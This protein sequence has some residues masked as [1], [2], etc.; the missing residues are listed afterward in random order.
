MKLPSGVR[1]RPLWRYS[2][3]ALAGALGTALVA[4]C[5]VEPPA[6]PS[7]NFVISIPV[8]NDSTR[9]SELVGDRDD[10]LEIDDVTGGMKLKVTMPLPGSSGAEPEILGTA[11]V[12]Q[13]LK[14]TPQA[15]SFSTAIGDLSIPGQTI[16]EVEV[17]MSTLLGRDIPTGTTIPSLPGSTFDIE[18]PMPLAGVT[19]LEIA[20]GGLSVAVDNGFPVDLVNL[21]LILRDN[22]AG[23]AI[24]DQIDLGTVAANGGSAA[25][26]FSLEGRTISGN[27]A[28]AVAGGTADGTDLTVDEDPSL[29]INSELETLLVTRATALIPQQEFE[30]S[31]TLDF[32]DDRIQVTEAV[33]SEGDI[34]LVVTNNIPI[35]MEVELSLPD[36]QDANGNAQVLLLDSLVAG[37]PREITFDLTN[38]TF[39][40]DHPLQMRLAYR[41]RT[42]ASD[43][44]VTIR[45]GGEI[46]IQA[47]TEQ[48]VFTRVQGRLNEISLTIPQQQRDVEFPDGLDN[49]SIGDANLAVFVTS[50]VGFLAD[51][52]ILFTGTNERGTETLVVRETFERGNPDNPKSDILAVSSADL[53]RFLNHLPTSITV[54]PVVIVGDGAEEEIIESD[55]FVSLDSVVFRTAPRLTVL[56][57]TKIDPDPE[58]ISFRDSEARD[59]I[60]TN[61][62]S[63]TVVTEIESSIPVGIGVRL[64][65]AR[66]P[67]TV[68]TDPV[69]TVPVASEPPFQVPAAPVDANGLSDG[70]V[71]A[72][73]ELPILKEQVLQFLLEDDPNQSLFAGVR[74]TLPETGG[75][76][77]VRATDFINV[78]A[79]L[80]VELE[81]NEDLVK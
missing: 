17:K 46:D 4:G 52:D 16:P 41:A 66:D 36:L 43:T 78:I 53:T 26:R 61:F 30:D 64:Y 56:A 76:V 33:M 74:V 15:N 58:D 72:T 25:G 2:A 38:N 11:E 71:T 70:T 22:S 40:P 10:F 54:E 47:L 51:V 42:F 31:Q 5:T 19:A 39:A 67:A 60:N 12:G 9:V 28:L 13:N 80:R 6:A 8:A 79:G 48:M 3:A 50:G 65:V 29:V 14:V 45:S 23:G 69:T 20:T 75:E 27:L 77:E 35:V 1:N 62:E 49:V 24:V 34:T 81:L 37:Q 73:Q 57:E 63:A 59:K 21:A 55:H 7:T 32:P 44:E 18:V 68:Y